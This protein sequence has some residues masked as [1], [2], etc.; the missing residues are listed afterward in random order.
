MSSQYQ[1]I[2]LPRAA[3]FIDRRPDLEVRVNG[4]LQYLSVN[5]YAGPRITHLKG[6][7][8]CRRRWREGDYRILYDI[9]KDDRVVEV[10]DADNRGQIY[11]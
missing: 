3:R 1:V 4:I 5:P 11:R 6:R 9:I 7:F 8:H 10:F 2:M